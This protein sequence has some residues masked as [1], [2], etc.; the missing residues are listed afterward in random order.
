MFLFSNF[1]KA[2]I[3]AIALGAAVFL[4][5]GCEGFTPTDNQQAQTDNGATTE[6]VSDIPDADPALGELVTLRGGVN[7]IFDD[8]SFVMNTA[9]GEAIL[10]LNPAGQTL[11]VLQRAGQQPAEQEEDLN[12]P[13]QVTGTLEEL[14]AAQLEQQYGLTLAPNLPEDYDQELVI[15]AE[16]I[17]LAPRPQDFWDAPENYFDETVAIEG[18]LRPL[19]NTQNALALFE[20]GWINDVGVL[21]LGTEQLVRTENLEQGENVVVTG[22][23]QLIDAATLQQA[24][25]GWNEAQIQEFITRYENRPV[26]QAEEV[27]PS[28]QPPH[29]IL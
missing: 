8:N 13:L 25:L 28:A 18:D 6:A 14:N 3:G 5:T 10:V 2:H 4:T 17:A 23:A 26:I 22:Q 9:D 24:N 27:Y 15:V 20:E 1:G 11:P 29:P 12:I 21:V 19:E 16:N 7:N